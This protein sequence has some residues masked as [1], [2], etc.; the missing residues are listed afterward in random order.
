MLRGYSGGTVQDFHLFPILSKAP[1][2]VFVLYIITADFDFVNEKLRIG[3][4]E[5]PV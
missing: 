1:C 3:L 4:Y 5:E 2:A